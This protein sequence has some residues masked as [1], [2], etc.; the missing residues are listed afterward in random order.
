M[1]CGY[2]SANVGVVIESSRGFACLN[3]RHSRSSVA[4][5]YHYQ[6]EPDFQITPIEKIRLP[7]RSRDE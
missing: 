4:M 5:R 3:L 2:V 7:L 1:W 6:A